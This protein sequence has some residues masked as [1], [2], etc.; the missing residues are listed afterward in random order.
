MRIAPLHF[1]VSG[2]NEGSFT[3]VVQHGGLR[4]PGEGYGTQSKEDAEFKKEA[5]TVLRSS[6]FACTLILV[7][8]LTTSATADEN[9]AE[10]V[11]A[12]RKEIL[13]DLFAAEVKS[14]AVAEAHKKLSLCRQWSLRDAV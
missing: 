12:M 8:S 3:P 9:E 6:G 10:K 2:S 7:A 11:K 1:A 5:V 4:Q 14:D 13:K